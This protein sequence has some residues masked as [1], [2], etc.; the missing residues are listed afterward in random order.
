[1]AAAVATRPARVRRFYSAVKSDRPLLVGDDDL[2]IDEC[3]DWKRP[4]GAHDFGEP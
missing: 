3:V 1:M 2:A 4:A